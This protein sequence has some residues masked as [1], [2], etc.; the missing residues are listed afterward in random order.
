MST[1]ETEFG[2]PNSGRDTKNEPKNIVAE[3]SLK[4]EDSSTMKSF[5]SD[6]LAKQ[7]TSEMKKPVVPTAANQRFDCCFI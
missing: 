4:N 3:K 6:D 1:T 5:D 2:W 7:L